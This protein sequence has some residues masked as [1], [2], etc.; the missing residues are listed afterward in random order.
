MPDNPVT[1]LFFLLD[2]NQFGMAESVVQLQNVGLPSR[3]QVLPRP[4]RPNTVASEISVERKLKRKEILAIQHQ[5]KLLNRRLVVSIPRSEITIVINIV[6][7]FSLGSS[8]ASLRLRPASRSDTV[9][10]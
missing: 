8:S 3:L 1:P 7:S 10:S 5:F 4:R 6:L 9:K 2:H